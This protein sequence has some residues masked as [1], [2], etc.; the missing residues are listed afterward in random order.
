MRRL[1]MVSGLILVVKGKLATNF[2]D[3]AK[4]YHIIFDDGEMIQWNVMWMWC[5]LKYK[6]SNCGIVMQWFPTE[7]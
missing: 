3:E 1:L 5:W 4:Y 2:Y 6:S 7:S